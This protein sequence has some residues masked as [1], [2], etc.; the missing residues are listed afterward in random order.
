M[1]TTISSR[2]REELVNMN[3]DFDTAGDGGPSSFRPQSRSQSQNHP[4]L[5]RLGSNASNASIFEEVEMAHDEVRLQS[6]FLVRF[7][8]L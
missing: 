3:G 1:N 6:R 8:Y 7:F 4:G 5:Y 2:D